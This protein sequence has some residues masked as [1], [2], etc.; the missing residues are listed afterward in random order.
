[1]GVGVRGG[2]KAR[3]LQAVVAYRKIPLT[4]IIIR[5]RRR[6]IVIITQII[7]INNYVI[8]LKHST[9][10]Q[11]FCMTK[12]PIEITQVQILIYGPF[13]RLVVFVRDFRCI[14]VEA[15]D[16]NKENLQLL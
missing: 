9:L 5:R 15:F 4:I 12:N 1:M 7:I 13:F 11:F 14:T 6:R 16:L 2:G 10:S 8:Y 3:I